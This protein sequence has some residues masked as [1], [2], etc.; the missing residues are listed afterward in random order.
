MIFQKIDLYD[1][2]G[3]K[4]PENGQGYLYAYVADNSRAIDAD[5]KHPAMLVIPGGGYGMTS[6]REAEP[7]ALEYLAN[8]FNSFVLRYSCAPV[9]H[10]YQLAEAIMAMNYIRLNAAELNCNPDMVAAVGFS[11]GGHLCAMLGSIW[12]DRSANKIFRSRINAKPNAIILAYPVITSSGRT[13]MGSFFNLCGEENKKLQKKLDITALV[14]EKSSPAFIWSTYTDEAV[15][16]RNALLAAT[17]YESVGV[18]FSLHIWGSGQHGLS[19]ANVC[20]YG[21]ASMLDSATPSVSSWVDL[22][23]EWLKENGIKI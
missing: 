11:A 17:A 7:V 3:V 19:L 4:R 10:P 16:C 23:L 9:R 8:N 14:N 2:F 15:P 22:S 21:N 6:D 20:V 5:R 18:P 13:H 1:Y 12:D